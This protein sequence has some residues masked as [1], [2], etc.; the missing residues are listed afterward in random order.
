MRIA[1]G[2]QSRVGKDTFAEMIRNDA[3]VETHMVR[4]A[5]PIADIVDGIQDNLGLARA[6]DGVL[7]QKLGSLLRWHYGDTLFIDLAM[8]QVE[9]MERDWSNENI[10]VTDMRDPIE[11]DALVAAGFTTIRITRPGRTIDRDPSHSSEVGLRGYDFDYVVENSG[12][13]DDLRDEVRRIT[14]EIQNKK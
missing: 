1:L 11:Y 8:N 13:L 9:R 10:I 6:K 7:M 3:D 12:S 5:Q 2:H 14:G 4:I